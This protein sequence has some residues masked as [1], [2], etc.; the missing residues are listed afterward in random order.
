MTKRQEVELETAKLK[1][2]RLFGGMTKN[3]WIRYN[4]IR[5]K[6]KVGK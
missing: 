1:M 4:Y 3:G 2:L 6:S 5:G